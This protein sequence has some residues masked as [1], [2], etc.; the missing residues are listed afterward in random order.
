MAKYAQPKKIVIDARNRRSSTGRYTDRLIENLQ[1]IDNT[2]NYTI[3]I[4][5]GD[6]WRMKNKNFRTVPCRF[7]Q[8]SFNPLDQI[9]FAWQLH[10]LK[11]D[12]VHFTMTQ[13]PLLYFDRIVTTTHDLTMLEHTRPSRFPAWLHSIGM[14]L[15]RFLFW[16]SHRKSDRIIVPTNYV[17]GDLA[18]LEPFTAK[19]TVVTHEA[20]D[21][22]VSGKPEPLKGVKQPFILHVGAPY[23]HKNIKRLIQAFAKL[24]KTNPNLQLILPGNM[25]DQFK[26]DFAKWV[27]AS[28]A[29]DSIQA[30]GFVSDE[31][32]KW[33]YENA[34]AYVLPSLSEGFGIPGL[35]AMLHG[36]P[37][38]SSNATC[39]PEVYG[40]AAHYFDPKD[41]DD[42]AK[43]MDEVIA[44]KKL[45][46]Q[47]VEK[48]K[49][50]V[51]KYSWAKMAEETLGVYS[52][53]LKV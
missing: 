17:K 1:D 21:L 48:G 7:A 29:R 35:E 43:K 9:A 38:V 6:N 8:F 10:R 19:K 11:P 41:T 50:Q 39:L 51:K 15:Y 27:G 5:P 53:T 45:Q 47:L 40:E 30:P 34:E 32:L 49:K 13:Q 37:L 44:D 23:P 36:C 4:E 46:K 3:L 18:K 25:K 16:W 12:L 14:V 52:D 26:R 22:P 42:M 31:E 20:A 24:K 2:N 33:L 28:P